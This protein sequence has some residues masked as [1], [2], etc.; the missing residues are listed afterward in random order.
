MKVV[1]IF[2]SMQGEGAY[3]GRLAI[4]IRFAGCNLSCPFCDEHHKYPQASD[5]SIPEILEECTK[6]DPKKHCIIV[7]TGGEP[8]IQPE[9]TTLI[10]VLSDANWLVHVET[11]GTHLET[12]ADADW[13]TASPKGPDY[14]LTYEGRDYKWEDELISEVKLV[15]SDDLTSDVIKKTW[16]A[17]LKPIWL[18][19][20]DGPTLEESRQRII[21]ILNEMPNIVRAGIQLH[22]WYGVV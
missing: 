8:S 19:P 18:Q 17:T 16:N 20:C 10:K 22:K 6:L 11:N 21:T 2:R 7:L 13:I 5:K 14:K 1:E 3:M 4:F 9:I 12:I 15:V